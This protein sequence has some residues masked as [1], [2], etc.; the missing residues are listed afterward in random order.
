MGKMSFANDT[1][2]I[3]QPSWKLHSPLVVVGMTVQVESQDTARDLRGAVVESWQSG[4]M[5]S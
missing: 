2:F 5:Y 4:D 3:L 1:I